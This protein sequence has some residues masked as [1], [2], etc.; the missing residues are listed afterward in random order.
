MYVS[1]GVLVVTRRVFGVALFYLIFTT[2]SGQERKNSIQLSYGFAHARLIDD[3]YSRNLL[4]R[5]TNSKFVFGYTRES[6]NFRLRFLIEGSAGNVRSKSGNLPSG[7][8]TAQPSF[9][10]LRRIKYIGLFAGPALI[11]T[12]YF[13]VNQPTFDNASMMSLHGLYGIITKDVGRFRISYALPAAVYVNRLL[14]NGGASNL[15]FED[16]QH[17][18]KTLTANGSFRYFDLA[19]VQLR[20]DYNKSIGRKTDFVAGYQFRYFK[21]YYSNELIAGLKFHF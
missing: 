4:F 14:W 17:P 16:L 18:V 10:Y 21:Y 13:I 1:R 15:S 3:G 12:T 5:G 8:Y 7:F 19:N 20:V 11:S 2:T 6:V 9:E